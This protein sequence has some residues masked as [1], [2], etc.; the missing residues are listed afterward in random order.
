MSN[1]FVVSKSLFQCASWYAVLL[2]LIYVPLTCYGLVQAKEFQMCTTTAKNQTLFAE[3]VEN[4]K[5]FFYNMPLLS[6][7]SIFLNVSMVSAFLV[8]L[9]VQRRMRLKREIYN[10]NR[11]LH[12]QTA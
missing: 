3:C 7:L 4:K 5:E 10:P 8:V 11:L 1:S 9:Y 12:Q 6:L 2:W